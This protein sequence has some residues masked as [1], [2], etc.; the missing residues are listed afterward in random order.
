MAYN[1]EHDITPKSITKGIRD[2]IENTMAAEEETEFGEEFSI[3]DIVA[4]LQNLE[5]EMFKAAEKLDFERAANIRDQIAELK[6]QY[7]IKD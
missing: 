4:M 5:T 1:K 7:K 6:E 3:D 2:V